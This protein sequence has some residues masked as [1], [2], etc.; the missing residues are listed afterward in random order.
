MAW[1]SPGCG[2]QASEIEE[3]VGFI[4]TLTKLLYVSS[5]YYYMC[6]RLVL[7]Q[8]PSYYYI[9]VSSYY[10]ICVSS[11]YYMC[12]LIL[13]CVSSCYYMCVLML[14]HVCPHGGACWFLSECAN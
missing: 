10:Y 4:N 1:I 3:H 14:L 6:V 9:C 5:C 2:E 12:V 11:Y 13:L 7:R 8:V